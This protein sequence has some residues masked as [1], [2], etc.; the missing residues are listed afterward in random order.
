MAA[1]ASGSAQ[2]TSEA[3][4]AWRSPATGR[5]DGSVRTGPSWIDV[6]ADLGAE[7]GEQLLG[8]RAGGD[9]GR[10]LAGRGPLEHVAG[11]VE[12][13]LLHAG[14]VGVAGPGRGQGLLGGAGVG[15]HLLGPLAGRAVPLA[16][17]DLDG[18]RR[19]EGAAVADAGDQGDLVGLEAHAGAP[20]VA[21]AAPGQLVG[22][23]L[24]GELEA[25]GHALEDDDEGLAV[26]FT[27]G[28][29]AQHR[30]NLPGHQAPLGDGCGLS[31]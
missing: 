29:V 1:S 10:G 25:R 4:T 14:E 13:V 24:D 23:V 12:V 8:H 27:G 16:V 5:R 30:T 17:G 26:G 15:R 31:P 18:D 9:P 7:G 11:V 20:A 28:Q 22:D 3:S 21:E 2:R 6:G 19:P